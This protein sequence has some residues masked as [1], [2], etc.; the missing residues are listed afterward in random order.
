MTK[1]RISRFSISSVFL[2]EQ[3][4]D[5]RQIA[6]DRHLARRRGEVFAHQPA[7]NHGVAV[8]DDDVGRDLRDILI[9]QRKTAFDADVAGRKLGM[10]F[11]ADH[12]VVGDEGPQLAAGAPTSRKLTDCVVAVS[13]VL[14][15]T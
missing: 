8:A 12:T 14:V 13:V 2:S 4:A 15:L 3:G 5:E 9:R 10:H 1:T 11:H 6:D 7:D